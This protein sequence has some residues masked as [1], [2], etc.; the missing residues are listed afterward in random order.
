MITKYFRVFAYYVLLIS[1]LSVHSQKQVSFRQLSVKDGLSQNSAISIT[2]DHAGFLWIATQDGLNKYDGRSFEKH[3]QYFKDITNPTYS[4]LGK[5]FVDSQDE[6]WILPITQIPHKLNKSTNSFEPLLDIVDASAIFEDH[7]KNLWFGSYSTGLYRLS[8]ET[9]KIKH[10]I[11]PDKVNTINAITQDQLGNLWLSCEKYIIKIDP[12]QPENIFY[13]YPDGN[14]NS[15]SNY[16]F[17]LFDQENNQWIGTFGDGVWY[18]ESKESNFKRPDIFIEDLENSLNSIYVI[19]M[20]LDSKNQLWIGT[21]GDGLFKID[22]AQSQLNQYLPEKH[23]PKA[24]QYK[25]I[26][27]IYEDY[28]GT[29]WFGTDGA[30]LNYYDALLEK[31]NS[32]INFQT[33]ENINIDVVR[34]ITLDAQNNVWIGTSG[35]GLSRFSPKKNEWTTYQT[36]NK[37]GLR[38]N[39]I[40]SLLSAND[41]DLWIGTQEG[42]LHIMDMEEQIIE[43]PNLKSLENLTV[44]CMLN[45]TDEDKWIGTREGGLLKVNKHKGIL[46]KFIKSDSTNGLPSNNIRAIAQEAGQFLWVGTQDNGISKIDL[47]T[48]TIRSYAHEPGN[49]NSL[50]SNQI[51]SLH[52]DNKGILWIGT[53]GSGL[54]ALD[55]VNNQFYNYTTKDGLANDVVYAILPDEQNNLWLSSNRG[56]TKFYVPDNLS[57]KPKIVNYTNYDGLATEFNTGAYYKAR[58]GNLYFGGLEGYY[59]FNPSDIEISK[60]L[61]KTVITKFEIYNTTKPLIPDLKLNYKQNTVAFSFASLQFSLPVKNQYQFQLVGH[62]TDWIQSGNENSARYTNLPPGNYT[63]KVKSSNYDGVWNAEKASYSFIIDNPWYLTNSAILMYLLLVIITLYLIYRYF[64]WRWNMKMQLKFERQETERFKEL[65]DFKA[66][67]Y[68][69]IS[70]EF[71]TPLTLINGPIKK[72][73]GN[74]PNA[75][76]KKDLNL[77]DKNTKRLLDLV[78][79]M[80]E[81]NK[82]DTGS[83]KVNPE[84]VHLGGFI[85]SLLE[86]FEYLA[87]NR[88]LVFSHKLGPVP[89][90]LFDT[91]IMEKII[92]NLLGN[93]IKYTPTAGC[94]DFQ[95]EVKDTNILTICIANDIDEIV[96]KDT[97]KFFERF[98]QSNPTNE[99][100]G[101]GLSLVKELV[102]HLQGTVNA[103]YSLDQKKISFTIE[104]PIHLIDDHE[105]NEGIVTKINGHR[106]TTKKTNQVLPLL[107]LVEDN[108]SLLNFMISLL[109][110]KYKIITSKDGEEGINMALKKIPDLII[111][112]LMMPKLNG[113]ELCNQLKNDEKTSHI[114]IIMLTGKTGPENEI[115]G[116]KSGV[117]EYMIKPFNPKTFQI[118][119]ENILTTRKKLRAHYNKENIFKPKD[120]AFTSTDEKFLLKVEDIL[121]NYLQDSDFSAEKFSQLLGMSRMQLHRKLIALTGY[122]TTAFIRLERLKQ[123]QKLLKKPGITVAEVAYTTGFNTPSYFIKCYKKTFGKT[124]MS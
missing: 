17:I 111:T 92:G 97:H 49:K 67:L 120:I 107:L 105:I 42:G 74:N 30:G 84:K 26:L 15:N 69:N 36:D 34:S 45:D 98:Y 21:Y 8:Y 96:E 39:R 65:N 86:P 110:D 71:R 102:E 33:P 114:P 57:S 1:C 40:M 80:L 124:P 7:Q 122:N 64:K 95:A 104:I 100:A 19:T 47:K 61:P 70:H 123:A 38:S 14:K 52:Y 29:L 51:K 76:L 4:K 73:L 118:R 85:Q 68:S 41:G 31:F 93:A 10:I 66:K 44:W 82:L 106:A 108:I 81:L 25:D 3:Q 18:K 89:M 5:V 121:N 11:G 94:I 91:D 119:I 88:N 48:N 55:I 43:Y 46:K 103:S 117:E 63:F 109:E 99:G 6:L 9:K 22:L 50:T 2:Q 113:I 53:N 28:T 32:V 75:S 79:Q 62:D 101:I 27:S 54:C 58:N 115:A 112:D 24:I 12:T 13:Y 16:S 77:V 23:N 60:V 59:W 87:K 72:Q 56:I 78:N 37:K 83:L 35:K 20:L 116:L 90:T